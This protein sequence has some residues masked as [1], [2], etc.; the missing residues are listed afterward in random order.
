K[1]GQKISDEPG[2]IIRVVLE[3]LALKYRYRLEQ[4]EDLLGRRLEVLHI[5]GGG[6]QNKLLNQLG[7]DAVSRPVLSGPVEATAAGNVLMQMLALGYIKNLAEG[8]A[9]IGN[10]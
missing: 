7:A 5:V 3:G 8:R 10:S 4:L 9:I 1:S 2:A 6:T